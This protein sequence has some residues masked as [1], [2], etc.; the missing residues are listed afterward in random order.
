M[1]NLFNEMDK[2]V[3]EI[4][5]LSIRESSIDSA[6]K[7]LETIAYHLRD[8]EQLLM[9]NWMDRCIATL[10]KETNGRV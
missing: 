3:E 4:M 9:A 2:Q 5:S 10:K 7:E 6:I 8:T 1:G